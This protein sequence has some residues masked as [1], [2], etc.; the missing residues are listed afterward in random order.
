MTLKLDA[1]P[2]GDDALQIHPPPSR[3]AVDFPIRAPLNDLGQLGHLFRRQT[4]R[5]AARPI[6]LQT[7]QTERVEAVNPI[8]QRLPIHSADLGRLSALPSV[9]NRRKRKQPSAL[10]RILR[11]SRQ[12]AKLFG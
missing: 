11:T 3:D 5:R 1:E 2:L 6:V 8:A 12:R 7:V 10:G 4:R 9:L